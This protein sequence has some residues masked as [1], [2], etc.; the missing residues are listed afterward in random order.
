[1]ELPASCWQLVS[2]TSE[3]GTL[4]RS[5]PTRPPN[6]ESLET[7]PEVV[8][9][10]PEV[11]PAGVFGLGVGVGV[12]VGVGVGVGD[13]VGVGVGVGVGSVTA[14]EAGAGASAVPAALPAVTTTLIVWPVSSSVSV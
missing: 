9:L 10:P 14:A 3:P 5:P 1:M 13:G 12:A 8:P 2:E 7:G 4:P 11:G 6:A